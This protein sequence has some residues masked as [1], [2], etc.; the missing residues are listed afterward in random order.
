MGG[1]FGLML[2]AAT[3]TAASQGW[4]PLRDGST[5]NAQGILERHDKI[6]TN[7]MIR[8]LDAGTYTGM[9]IGVLGMGVASGPSA[10]S[11]GTG[12]LGVARGLSLGAAAGS[13]ATL[14]YLV[15]QDKK[16]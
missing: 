6:A 15:S 5:W 11:L 9:L 12:V 13:I 3:Y 1:G 2:G 14:G 7:T 8:S 10:L 4:M 16:E